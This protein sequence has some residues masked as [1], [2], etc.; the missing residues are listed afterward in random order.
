[1]DYRSLIQQSTDYIEEHVKDPLTVELLAEQVGFSPYHYYRIFGEY[2]GMPVMDFIRRRRMLH[3]GYDLCTKDARILDVAL[4]YG[5][6]THAGFTRAFLKYMG[7]PPEKY[8]H[9]EVASRPERSDLRR[10]IRYS[11]YGGMIMEPKIVHRDAITVA[12]YVMDTTHEDGKNDV[13]IPQFWQ[14]YIEEKRSQYLA[15]LPGIVPDVEY[16]ICLPA[17]INTGRFQYA[18]AMKTKDAELLPKDLFTADIP[19]G[20]YAVFATPAADRPQFVQ[21]IQNSWCYINE[22][23]FPESGYEFASGHPDFELYDKRCWG[24]KNLVME[25][26]IPVVKK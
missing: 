12:G 23:W 13:E 8:R 15:G 5:F 1:M 19:E 16:G 20:L 11:T 21:T 25:I 7:L 17:D 26:W 6:E 2:V 3:A 22:T 9:T 10:V 4:D 18:I 14:K 24:D